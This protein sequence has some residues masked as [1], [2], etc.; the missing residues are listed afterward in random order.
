VSEL[1]LLSGGVDSSALAAWRRPTQTLV[2]NYGQTSGVGEITA[3]RAVAQE[4]GLPIEVLHADCS[5]VGSGLLAG[6]DPD[7][8]APV[9]EWW[10]FRNQLLV[11]LAAAWALPRGLDRVLIGSVAGDGRHADGTAEFF[12]KLDRLTAAQEGGIRVEVPAINLSTVELVARS[13]ISDSALGWTHS[14]HRGSV[15]CGDCPGCMK[16]RDVL[17]ELDRLQ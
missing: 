3:A 9:P 6:N 7:P 2:L 17:H 8:A 1:L 12:E 13:G 4:L 10:P 16:R 14:C 15:A 11:T 5:A